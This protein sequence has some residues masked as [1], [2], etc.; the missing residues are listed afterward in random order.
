MNAL[1]KLLKE[2]NWNFSDL[3]REY[4]KQESPELT[5]EEAIKKYASLIRKAVTDPD[6]TKHGT[7][8][9]LIEILGGELVVRVK[10]VEE[11]SL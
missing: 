5:E 7:V 9:R 1:G 11:L 10:R 8:K 4:A 6:H 2:R 3:A